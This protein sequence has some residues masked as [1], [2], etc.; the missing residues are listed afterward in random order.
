MRL[1]R[2]YATKDT[3]HWGYFNRDLQPVLYVD[4]GDLIE[5][6]TIT[7]HAGDAPDLMMDEAIAQLFGD[8]AMADRGPGKHILTGPIHVAGAQ[9]G[10]MLEVQFLDLIPR[11]PYGSNVTASW[12]YL[13]SDLGPEEWVTIYEFDEAYRTARPIFRFTYPGRYDVPGQIIAAD[14]VQREPISRSISVPLRPHVGCAGVAPEWSGRQSTVPPGHHGGNVDNWRLGKGAKAFYPV[15]VE[16]AL[17]SLGDPH[18]AQGDGELTGTAIESSLHVL[19]RVMVRKDFYLPTPVIETN[20]MWMIHGFS[21][22]LNEAA[23]QAAKYTLR[24]LTDIKGLTV[25]EAYSLM[26]AGVDFTITQV[27]NRT[28][29]VHT[30]IPKAMFE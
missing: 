30:A 1:H 16:G 23:R 8:V 20:E 4:S 22:D 21:P 25:R 11:H 26:S 13:Y 28:F 3:V 5:V 17:L 18:A 2:L 15:F 7:H 9:P 10:D 6:E 27:A 19:I 14:E 24:F 29:G 12:G